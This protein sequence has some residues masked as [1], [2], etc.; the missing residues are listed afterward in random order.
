MDHTKIVPA[1]LKSPCRELSI[2]GL[3]FVVTPLA[4]S[5]I[6]FFVCVYTGGN[7]VVYRNRKQACETILCMYI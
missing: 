4:R 3:G 6:D 2:R 1:D 7:P 5:G